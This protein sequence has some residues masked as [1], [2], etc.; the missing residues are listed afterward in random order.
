LQRLS[1]TQNTQHPFLVI[2]PSVSCPAVHYSFLQH[3][4]HTKPVPSYIAISCLSGFH[5]LFIQHT[6][7]TKS[8]HCYIPIFCLSGC[9]LPS[10]IAHNSHKICSLLY[11]HLMPVMLYITQKSITLNTQPQFPV[12]LTSVNS[13][14]VQYSVIKQENTKH[15]SLLYF[16]LLLARFTLLSHPSH[17]HTTR[18]P[19]RLP[20]LSVRLTSLSYP[21]HK[22]HNTGAPLYCHRLTVRMY[23]TQLPNTQNT[24]HLCQL[25]LPSVACLVGDYLFPT[26]PKLTTPVPCYKEFCCLSGC[27]LIS[28]PAHKTH[29]TFSLKY[30]R[31]LPVRMY[32]SQ[33]PAKYT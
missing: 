8:Y 19:V 1:C 14:A 23:V 30:C 24:Q 26:H 28:Y 20:F 32:I 17:K 22:T 27:T 31:I 18:L 12:I 13:Q 15:L 33:F 4:K 3:T 7:H 6:K 5:Y 11:C 10:N 16:H 29:K 2:L 9:T 25:I 21:T